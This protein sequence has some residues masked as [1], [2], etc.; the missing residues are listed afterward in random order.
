MVREKQDRNQEQIRKM[1]EP[2]NGK[3]QSLKLN[4][5]ALGRINSRSTY[6]KYETEVK[7]QGGRI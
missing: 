5:N 2:N 1:R 3:V 6:E 7:R 4:N